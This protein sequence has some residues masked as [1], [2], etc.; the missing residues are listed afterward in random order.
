MI[1]VEKIIITFMSE[2]N[3]PLNVSVQPAS[4]DDHE[5]YNSETDKAPIAK[6]K[7]VFKFSFFNIRV[8]Y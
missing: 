6:K 8:I 3:P 4:V 5:W 2:V 7:G 1:F